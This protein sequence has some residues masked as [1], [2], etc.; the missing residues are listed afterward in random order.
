[1]AFLSGLPTLLGA[2]IGRVLGGLDSNMIALTM[3][4][5]GGAMLFVV[6]KQMLTEREEYNGWGMLWGVIAGVLLTTAF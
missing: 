4:F 5:A 3:G 6:C 2:V 1:L